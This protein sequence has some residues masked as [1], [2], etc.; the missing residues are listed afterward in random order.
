MY[1]FVISFMLSYIFVYVIVIEDISECSSIYFKMISKRQRSADYI[2]FGP[3]GSSP[4]TT[5]SYWIR[6]WLHLLHQRGHC[7]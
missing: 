2:V 1:L 7:T 4:D 3:G 6:Q 5:Y